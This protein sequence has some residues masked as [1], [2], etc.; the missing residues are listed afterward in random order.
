MTLIH[1]SSHIH[2]VTYGA[3]SQMAFTNPHTYTLGSDIQC[4]VHVYTHSHMALHKFSHIAI[5]VMYIIILCMVHTV[6]WHPQTLTHNDIYTLG[7]DTQCDSHIIIHTQ[8]HGPSRIF[9]HNYMSCTLAIICMVH[10]VTW[11]SQTLTHTCTL[12][13]GSA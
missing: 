6:T 5:H 8:S 13:I 3:H 4:H 11:H 10:T 9:T 12:A 2:Y 1:K 7:S